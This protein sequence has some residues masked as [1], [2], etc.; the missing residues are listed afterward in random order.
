MQD[1][2]TKLTMY[3]GEGKTL[4]WRFTD[5]NG[6]PVDLTGCIFFLGA[7]LNLTDQEYL[8][9][10]QDKDFDHKDASN[11]IVR[12]YLSA[13][14]TMIMSAG[15]RTDIFL[16]LKTIAA[17]GSEVDKTPICRLTLLPTVVHD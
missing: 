11:G 12:L 15:E 17:D 8:F 14:D 9:S 3:K 7:K 16:Q 5:A 1:S 2:T 10:Y 6:Q 13:S 4:V